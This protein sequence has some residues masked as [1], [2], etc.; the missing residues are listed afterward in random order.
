MYS[1]SLFILDWFSINHGLI[2]ANCLQQVENIKL[3][4]MEHS[5][6]PLT[7]GQKGN[8][9]NSLLDHLAAPDE[10]KRLIILLTVIAIALDSSSLIQ[11]R[12]PRHPCLAHAMT[13]KIFSSISMGTKSKKQRQ[14]IASN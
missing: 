1:P 9:S 4:L 6:C 3:R 7:Q 5:E 2:D 11:L 14:C 13:D 12:L 8:H 10:V